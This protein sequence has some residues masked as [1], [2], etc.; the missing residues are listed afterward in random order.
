MPLLPETKYSTPRTIRG[1]TN[2]ST[3][4][5]CTQP[6][7]SMR[8]LFQSDNIDDVNEE[9]K[10]TIPF[11]TD[12]DY[13]ETKN[14]Y[15]VPPTTPTT[16]KRIVTRSVST[17]RNNHKNGSTVG[18]VGKT[19]KRKSVSSSRYE[20]SNIMETPTK[21]SN[22][23]V[24]STND[25]MTTTTTTSDGNGVNSK[26]FP[27]TPEPLTP[28]VKERTKTKTKR[29]KKST[30]KTDKK[31]T[32]SKVSSILWQEPD[33]WRDTYELV[34]ELRKDQTAPCDT[35]GA[36][37]LVLPQI[38]NNDDEQDDELYA[39]TRRFQTLVALMLSS[40]TKDAMV[41]RAM[42]NLRN[43]GDGGLTIASIIA[44]DPEKLNLMIS[45]CGFRNNKTKYIKQVAEILHEQYHDDIPSTADEMIRNLP[46]IGPK[47]AYII[48]NICWE[49]QTG[50][51]VDT[52]MHRLFP[53]L[54]WVSPNTKNAEQTRKQLESWLPHSFWGEINLLWVGFGQEVQQEKQ[55]ILI[56]ALKSDRPLDALRLLRRVD[57][58]VVKEF[59]KLL[60]SSETKEEN[61]HSDDKG[62]NDNDHPW[63]DDYTKDK[64]K[65]MIKQVSQGKKK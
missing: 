12:S 7:R 1:R 9:G 22:M 58:E 46:G 54:K 65:E 53:K 37:G 41:G 56:K 32:K 34:R 63:R 40:Q 52:H 44:M 33:D 24:S 30:T 6:Q 64:M 20:D 29:K 31:T 38:E 59:D 35:L 62:K 42:G 26:V 27:V 61:D 36:E 49:K 19:N 51:G 16:K 25:I 60:L 8:R 13:N 4:P 48:E 11:S 14:D 21:R 2:T 5:I 43:N 3:N 39:K 15:V 28:S 18:A 47:M 23:Q 55:K 17:S 45:C 57:F 50:I 10:S